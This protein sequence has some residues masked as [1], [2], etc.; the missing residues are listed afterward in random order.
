MRLLF[1]CLFSVLI[2]II[3]P[4]INY[5]QGIPPND[6]VQKPLLTFGV[7]ADIQ[8]CDQDANGTRFYRSSLS[9]L[10]KALTVLKTDSV[11][12]IVNLGDMI[13]K[14]FGSYKPVMDI[15]KSSG[16]KTYHI[17]GNHDYS[18]E[19]AFKKKLPVL[20][21]SKRGYY[22]FVV[23]KI[24]LIFLNGNEVSA[25]ASKN[26]S[27]IKHNTDLIAGLKTK[28]EIN[29]FVWNGGISNKQ[30][31]WLNNQLEEATINDEKVIIMCHFP[32]VP[33]SPDN[34][35]NYKEV[36]RSLEKYHNVIA[37][38]NGHSHGG[39]YDVFDKIHFVTFKGMVESENENSFA[40]V[41]VFKDK[42]EIHGYGREKSRTLP[43]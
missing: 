20:N 5:S 21:Q 12:F 28:G 43:F 39:N 42:L 35:L 37:W 2:L 22:S 6:P 7:I 38:F 34:L 26:K 30:L 36:T 13:D 24:R 1:A 3:F 25:Y 14:G 27:V 18:V 32:V 41:K 17:T 4:G 10:E 19:P 16:V 31:N 40:L 9:K 15:I 33:D 8:Y 11:N 23:G 29:A